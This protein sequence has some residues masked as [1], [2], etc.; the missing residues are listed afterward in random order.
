MTAVPTV[1]S[2][3]ADRRQTAHRSSCQML[4][5]HLP[6]ARPSA[7]GCRLP[8]RWGLHYAPGYRTRCGTAARR[9]GARSRRVAWCGDGTLRL[10]GQDYPTGLLGYSVPRKGLVSITAAELVRNDRFASSVASIATAGGTMGRQHDG[11]NA[12]GAG[13][14]SGRSSQFIAPIIHVL[15]QEPRILHCSQTRLHCRR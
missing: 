4:R 14:I 5:L 9:L 10:L 7:S 12:P 15:Q 2:C 1:C 3:H 6:M 13:Q 11:S 8:N